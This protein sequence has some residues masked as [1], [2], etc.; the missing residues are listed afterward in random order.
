M[1]N[2]IDLDAARALANYK[3]DDAV[4]TANYSADFPCIRA[5]VSRKN[6]RRGSISRRATGW[7]TS[8]G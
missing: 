1:P 2:T 7:W 5:E 3:G 4:R 6:G 8:T